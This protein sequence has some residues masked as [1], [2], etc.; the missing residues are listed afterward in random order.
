MK[1]PKSE[2]DYSPGMPHSHCGPSSRSDTWFCRH[3]QVGFR[4]KPYQQGGCT[5][6]A[7]PIR[8]TMW[9]RLYSRVPSS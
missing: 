1:R 2:V 7:G 6:V 9:C 5:K 3:F 4:G 8:P